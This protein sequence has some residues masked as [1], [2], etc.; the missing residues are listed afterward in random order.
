MDPEISTKEEK[1]RLHAIPKGKPKSG[2][3]WK[4]NKGRFSAISRPKS[5]KVSYEDRI[6]MKTDLN[7]IR[8]REKQMWTVVNEKR[9]KLKQRQK[10]NKERQLINDRKGEVV[11]IIKNPAKIKRMKKKQQRA[12]EKRDLDK[13]KNKKSLTN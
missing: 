10:E 8:N 4:M 2:R 3:T 6:K 5:V 13:I 1:E 11:Q 7:E 9:D 12:V